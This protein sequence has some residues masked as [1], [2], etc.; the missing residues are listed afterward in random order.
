MLYFIDE[1]KI[2]FEEILRQEEVPVIKSNPQSPQLWNDHY[3]ELAIDS[4]D[5]GKLVLRVSVVDK[6]I[7]NKIIG[8]IMETWYWTPEGVPELVPNLFISSGNKVII[9]FANAEDWEGIIKNF[10]G[11]NLIIKL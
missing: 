2:F 4:Y 6:I 9:T 11:G 1:I 7:P 5:K 3:C 10:Y 8:K